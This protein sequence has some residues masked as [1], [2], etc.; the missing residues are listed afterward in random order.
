[1]PGLNF[2][3]SANVQNA[4]AGLKSVQQNLAATA[5]ASNQMGGSLAKASAS[6]TKT[7]RDFT[8][9]SRII[10]DLPFGFTAISNNL[11]QILPAAGA[12]GLAISAIVSAVTFA[13]VG[14]SSWTRGIKGAK[15]EIDRSVISIHNYTDALKS[16][17]ENSGK[18][19]ANLQ[20]LAKVATDIALPM[21]ARKKAV[22][23]LQKLYPNYLKNISDEAILT[24]QAASA[25][26]QINA[27]LVQ[28]AY[29]EAASTKLSDLAGRQLQLQREELILQNQQRQVSLELTKAVAE[30][31][32]KGLV[33]G[34]STLAPVTGTAVTKVDEL[35]VKL[36][37]VNEQVQANKQTQQDYNKQFDFFLNQASKFKAGSINLDPDPNGK[38]TEKVDRI[39]E[40]LRKLAIDR[41][42]LARNPLLSFSEKDQRAFD[43]INSAIN[44]LRDLKVS[45]DSAIIIRL[46]ADLDDLA[47]QIA[48]DR[49]RARLK[50]TGIANVVSIPVEFATLKKGSGLAE[51]VTSELQ[52]LDKY[53]GR[54]QK[55]LQK[56]LFDPKA[57]A[58]RQAE[59]AEAAKQQAEIITNTLTSV[60]EAAGSATSIRGFFGEIG[61]II[62]EGLKTLGKQV[63]ATSQLISTIKK[64]LNDALGG[65]P[66]SGIITGIGLIALGNILERS[67][68]KFAEGGIVNKAT[69]GVFGEAGPEAVVPLNKLPD[70]IARSGVGGAQ[71]VEVVGRLSGGDLFLSNARTQTS[72]RRLYG[73]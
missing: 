43:L 47:A 25:I 65:N 36:Q 12:A 57:F 59:I 28:R 17:L 48:S 38:A 42:E 26:L 64:A 49:F 7:G 21:E 54:T 30:E 62:G 71:Q 73:K 23:E 37:A 27:A 2:V 35:K 8:G 55:A 72:R 58:A 14:F 44:G 67:L 53:S 10:Q 34:G 40:L 61:H 22:D 1:M 66:I 11:T 51:V 39:A 32:R 18:E 68:P 5:A 41:E 46:R 9:L 19:I 29:Y 3:V 70:I 31:S 13:Q 56:L 16:G 4:N 6:V 50:K 60:F 15:D 52:Q 33:L 45:N 63:I 20:T 24:G 69:L